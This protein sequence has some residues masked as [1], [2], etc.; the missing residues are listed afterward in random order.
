MRVKSSIYPKKV[1]I[2]ETKDGFS[3]IALRKNVNSIV[4]EDSLMEEEIHLYEYDEV[5]I[6]VRHRKNIVNSVENNFNSWFTK[7]LKLEGLE[8]EISSK[9]KETKELINEYKQVDINKEL[10][11]SA[12]ALFD[13]VAETFEEVVNVDM[14]TM[15]AL[16]GV[17][18]V[19]EMLDEVMVQLDK[20][21]SNEKGS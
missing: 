5:K 19:Y 21:N 20:I 17:S 2:T 11:D 18:E 9:Q 15:A 1:E 14:V 16:E 6:R 13:G 7:G 8:K 3:T 10:S 4:E 12:D